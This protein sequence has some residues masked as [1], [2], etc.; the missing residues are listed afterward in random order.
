MSES[1]QVRGPIKIRL[2]HQHSEAK[3]KKFCDLNVGTKLSVVLF[4]LVAIVFGIFVWTIGYSTANMLEK[5]AE[6]DMTAKTYSVIGMIDVFNSDLKREAARSVKMLEGYFPGKFSLDGGAKVDVA[7]QSAPVMKSGSQKVNNDHSVPD[8][9]TARSGV[10]ATVFVRSGSD[11]IRV[12]T[13]LKD[14]SGKRAVGTVLDRN[15]PAYKRLLEGDAFGGVATLFNRKYFT[16]YS[17]IM[18]E[19]DKVIGALFVGVDYTEQ[20]KSITNRIHALQIGETG[21]FYALNSNEGPNYGVAVAGVGKEGKNFLGLKGADGREVVKELL[22]KKNGVLQYEAQTEDGSSR[23]RIAAFASFDEWK[24]VV[25]GSAYTDEVTKEARTLRMFA[26]LGGLISVIFICVALYLVIVRMV[27]Q[28]LGQATHIAEKIAS[29]DLSTREETTRNDEIGKLQKAV[30][31]ISLGLANVVWNVR[32]GT[33]TLASASKEIASGNQDLSSRTEEQAS[34][35]EETASSME[36]LTSTVRQNAENAR[37]ANQLAASASDIA[38]KGGDV[39]AEVVETMH[40][41]HDSSRRIADIINVI[42]GIAFQTNILALN[43][44]V[45]AA[46][47]GEQGRG[48]A[49]VATEVRSLAQRS[50]TA[51]REIKALIDDSVGKVAAG[52]KLVENAGATMQ[53]IVTSV[54]R[55]T[56]IMTEIAEASKEQSDGI[57][58]VNQAITQMDQVTQQNAALVE[59]SAAAAESMQGQ[60]AELVKQVQL[61]KLRTT[62]MGTADEA[63]ELVKK[64]LESLKERGREKTFADVSNPFG[65]Y[66]DRDLYVVVYNMNGKN[67][68]HGANPA[69]IGKDMIDGKDGAG[70]LF[71]RE[72][73]EI[74]KSK[75]GGW[76]DY[77]FL[78]P[79][80]KQME[81]KSMFLQQFDDLI[82]GCGI[83]RS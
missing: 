83:Y 14:Q 31:S 81:P 13:S 27:T 78:N 15:H 34:S 20:I 6:E 46:R 38:V 61:F 18:G 7:G 77:T 73:V 71:I 62:E 17:P 60:T 70:K 24:W 76:Q 45:E 47:A 55:V 63:V 29:G 22:A 80:S 54:K 33:G 40:A 67:L 43:A 51:A 35:L 65:G 36:Q 49:V 23:D 41:I 52:N 3:M 64:A 42:D 10:P 79:V 32:N 9:F 16:H 28:P 57:E 2:K 58:Q 69:N 4:V 72:R 19:G 25:V 8:R 48:F 56:D 44:A 11:F 66:T 75:G 1:L 37:Q 82:V 39:V 26:G 50:A 53:E 30:N 5:R 68:A 12:S 59:E 74:I 21:S